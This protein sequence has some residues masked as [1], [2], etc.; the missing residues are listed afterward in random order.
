MFSGENDHN[1]S[2]DFEFRF[3]FSA[4]VAASACQRRFRLHCKANFVIE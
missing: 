2:F 1:L 3:G 4:T